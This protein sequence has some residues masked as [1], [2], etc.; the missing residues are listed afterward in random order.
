MAFAVVDFFVGVFEVVFEVFSGEDFA[1]IFTA[2]AL[3]AVL[4][5]LLVSARALR[6]GGIL[7]IFNRN[8]FMLF[9]E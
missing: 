4:A 3:R 5:L 1:E 2:L 6:F 9:Q 8:V 7:A